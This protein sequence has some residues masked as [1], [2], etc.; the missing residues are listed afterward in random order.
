MN[1]WVLL[2]QSVLLLALPGILLNS[3]MRKR[4]AQDRPEISGALRPM[5]KVIISYCALFHRLK[6]NGWAPLPEHGPAI[7][8][9]NHTCGIDHMILQAG[10]RRVLGF[11]IAREFY[12]WPSIH[13]FCKLVH[14]IPV[15]RD[16]RDVHAT[17]RALGHWRKGESC[18]FSLKGESRRFQDASLVKSVRARRSSRFDQAP[19][20]SRPTSGAR[21]PQTKL[22]SP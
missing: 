14:C 5:H 11:M 21:R 6:T 16:G 22:A 20:S 3:W 7:L 1:G 8:I 17:R 12:E 4:E 18:R 9:A 2:V 10:C 19:Q 15:N 13:W